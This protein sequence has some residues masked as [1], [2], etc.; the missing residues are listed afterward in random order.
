M[1][2]KVRN[3]TWDAKVKHDDSNIFKIETIVTRVEERVKT[4][5]K[6]QRRWRW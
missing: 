3:E 6:E 4:S 2:G 1:E 5:R